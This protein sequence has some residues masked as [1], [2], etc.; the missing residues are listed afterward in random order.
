MVS[1]EHAPIAGKRTRTG[2]VHPT[3]G[4][5]WR[6]FAGAWSRFK[7]SGFPG[8]PLPQFPTQV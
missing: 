3:Q 7:H 2:K 5:G 6:I 4:I 1:L 8:H